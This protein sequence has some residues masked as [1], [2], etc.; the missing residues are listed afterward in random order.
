MP[1]EDRMAF[2]SSRKRKR[3]ALHEEGAVSDVKEPVGRWRALSF[4]HKDH[5]YV[6][7]GDGNLHEYPEEYQL[8]PLQRCDFTLAHWSGVSPVGVNDE[9]E[10]E[11]LARE[12]VVNG[13]VCCAVLGDCLRIRWALEVWI[14]CARVELG[15]NGLAKTRAPEPKRWPRAYGWSRDG[16]VWG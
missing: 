10:E 4:V 13:G 15:H 6:G 12:F 16:C 3:D 11:R 8:L 2:S 9:E 5:F 7:Q 14:H 1:L